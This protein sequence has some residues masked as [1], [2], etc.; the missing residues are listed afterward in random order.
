VV[1]FKAGQTATVEELRAFLGARFAKW[2][3]PEQFVFADAIPRTSTGK[4]NKLALREDLA[5]CSLTGGS[6]DPAP[7]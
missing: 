1:L 3:V 6:D 4:F 5:Q 2:M 7:A